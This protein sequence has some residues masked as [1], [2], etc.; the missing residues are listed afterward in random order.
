MPAL[1]LRVVALYLIVQSNDAG[2]NTRQASAVLWMKA[3]ELITMM[4]TPFIRVRTRI[5]HGSYV[6]NMYNLMCLGLSPIQSPSMLRGI[7][8]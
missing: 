8:N 3:V 1:P 4:L 6:E 7:Q 2:S 5:L